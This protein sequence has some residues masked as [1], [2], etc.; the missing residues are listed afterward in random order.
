MLTPDEVAMK[1][2]ATDRRDIA[3]S[4]GVSAPIAD[5]VLTLLATIAE[6]REELAQAH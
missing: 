3:R 6:L 4:C 2:R 5:D 1:E